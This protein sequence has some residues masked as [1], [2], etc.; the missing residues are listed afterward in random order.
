MKNLTAKQ[1]LA[2]AAMVAGIDLVWEDSYPR[3]TISKNGKQYTVPWNPFECAMDALELIALSGAPVKYRPSAHQFTEEE[4]RDA[5]SA[6][7]ISSVRAASRRGA[8]MFGPSTM[9][10][11]FP[12]V[13][14]E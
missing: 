1:Q 10:E 14:P 7:C 2:Y 3:K 11:K 6:M 9:K 8:R 5:I 4:K 12:D 13:F